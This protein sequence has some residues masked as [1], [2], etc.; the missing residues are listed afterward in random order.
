[1]A[2]HHLR[3][4]AC[5]RPYQRAEA[6]TS[7]TLTA[8]RICSISLDTYTVPH[9][10][11]KVVKAT[12][13]KMPHPHDSFFNSMNSMFEIRSVRFFTEINIQCYRT[14]LLS[15]FFSPDTNTMCLVFLYVFTQQ[16]FIVP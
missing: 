9:G 12:T 8:F 6:K 10:S 16:I 2:L 15:D 13:K 5:L 14:C 11:G 4:P 7:H 1:M 3:F